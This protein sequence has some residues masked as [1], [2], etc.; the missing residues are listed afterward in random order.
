MCILPA[1]VA[2]CSSLCMHYCVHF[3]VLSAR[4]NCHRQATS[5]QILEFLC[6]S[7]SFVFDQWPQ[8]AGQVSLCVTVQIA[9]PGR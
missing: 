4:C 5:A 8:G 7:K 1:L 3:S 2:V 6:L 9:Q